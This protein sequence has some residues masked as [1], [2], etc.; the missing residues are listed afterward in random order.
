MAS[1]SPALSGEPKE[2]ALV[3]VVIAEKANVWLPSTLFFEKKD[4][5]KL[6]LRNIAEKEHG[7]A[8]EGMDVEQLIAPDQTKEIVIKASK[9]GVFR[10]YCPLH[11][12]HIGGQI[13]IQ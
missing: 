10:F 7:F 6:T 1:V 12:G 4:E 3:T 11:K 8:I 5:V 13:V 9:K 2:A